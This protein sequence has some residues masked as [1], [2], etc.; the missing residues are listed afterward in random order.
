MAVFMLAR[1]RITKWMAL[2]SILGRMD[3]LTK[4]STPT[5]ANMAMVSISGLMGES[6]MGIGKMD[7]SMVKVFIGLNRPK[8]PKKG[9]GSKAKETSGSMNESLKT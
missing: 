7:V 4:D 2:G 5:T 6:T 9:S 8:S 3:A 1:A